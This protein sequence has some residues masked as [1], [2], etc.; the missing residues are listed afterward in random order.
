MS[1][2]CLAIQFRLC[3][4]SNCFSPWL[5]RNK[6]F[7]SSCSVP[8]RLTRL[9]ICKVERNSLEIRINPENGSCVRDRTRGSFK[10]IDSN[11]HCL[12]RGDKKQFP[13]S[14][15]GIAKWLPSSSNIKGTQRENF[16]VGV[17]TPFLHYKCPFVLVK[18][19]FLNAKKNVS[20]TADTLA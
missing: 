10:E 15:L 8:S 13:V 2:P 9:K 17:G 7:S 4:F 18:G 5:Q 20:V 6:I 19:L 1:F 3:N 11:S 16:T 14:N 12:L